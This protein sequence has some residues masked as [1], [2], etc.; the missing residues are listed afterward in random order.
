MITAPAQLLRAPRDALKDAEEA[1][2]AAQ[3]AA[4]D[5]MRAY[6]K[7]PTPSKMNGVRVASSREAQARAA[8]DRLRTVAGTSRA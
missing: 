5:A 8:F 6:C 3:R 2:G 7:D 4:F 1:L